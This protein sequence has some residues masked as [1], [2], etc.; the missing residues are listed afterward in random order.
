MTT[1][2]GFRAKRRVHYIRVRVVHSQRTR[3]AHPRLFFV[4]TMGVV[5]LVVRSIAFI[6]KEKL[7][8]SI[9]VAVK[10]TNVKMRTARSL[11]QKRVAFVVSMLFPQRVV[12]L[13]IVFFWVGLHPNLIHSLSRLELPLFSWEH[14][15]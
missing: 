14:Q 7:V 4:L 1:V 2:M 3:R 6:T 11:A 12:S 13:V 15:K 10:S 9:C 5:L 8:T